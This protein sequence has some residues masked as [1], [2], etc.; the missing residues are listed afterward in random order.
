MCLQLRGGATAAIHHN[1]IR[2]PIVRQYRGDIGD[3]FIVTHLPGRER[4]AGVRD[5]EVTC[6]MN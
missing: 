5:D 2:E 1:D 4:S 6:V 3:A